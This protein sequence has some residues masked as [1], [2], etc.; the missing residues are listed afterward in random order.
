[1]ASKTPRSYAPKAL[2]SALGHVGRYLR[3]SL[4][5]FIANV[6]Q[7]VEQQRAVVRDRAAL[8]RLP[9]ALPFPG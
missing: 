9:F 1:M 2:P 3:Q 7:G 4:A 6:V 5:P 8:Q